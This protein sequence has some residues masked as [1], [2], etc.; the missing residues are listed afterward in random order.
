[1]VMISWL[2]SGVAYGK[3]FSPSDGGY[4]GMGAEDVLNWS[5]AWAGDA[6]LPV[7]E[8]AERT[9]AMHAP[10]MDGPVGLAGLL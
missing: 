10:I 4:E 2:N 3:V 9:I 1:M 7:C 8:K 6:A 5:L